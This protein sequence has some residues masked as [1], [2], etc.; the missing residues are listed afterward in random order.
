MCACN[1]LGSVR[2]LPPIPPPWPPGYP[3][4]TWPRK[5]ALG[6]RNTAISSICDWTWNCIKYSFSPVL[7][8]YIFPF[9]F[10]TFLKIIFMGLKR[11][12]LTLRWF[13]FLNDIFCICICIWRPRSRTGHEPGQL[14]RQYIYSQWTPD[15]SRPD[16]F[17]TNASSSCWNIL[18]RP[19]FA[20]CDNVP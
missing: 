10:H 19:K 3:Y 6:T 12:S 16:P 15:M 17:V 14:E 9:H 18:E 2:L 1:L 5:L 7:K 4:Q 8:L 11:C 20:V 13:V